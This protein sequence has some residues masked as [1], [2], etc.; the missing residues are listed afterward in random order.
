MAEIAKEAEKQNLRDADEVRITDK[1]RIEL[2]RLGG[3]TV[4]RGTLEPG[5]RWS[6]HVKPI[7]G[8]ESCE[9]KHQIYVLSGNLHVRMNDGEE[10]V[11][12]P[13]DFASVAPGHDAWVEG[14][15]PFVAL[16][17]FAGEVYAKGASVELK[18]A[19]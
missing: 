5:W 16:E 18:R 6:E 7:A 1:M 12:E 4:A 17:L 11:L 9:V 3:T 8:T 14:E 19:A 13:G 2:V 15:A 10:L